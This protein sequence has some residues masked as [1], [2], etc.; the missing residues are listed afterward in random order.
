M[1]CTVPFA[2]TGAGGAHVMSLMA[3]ANWLLPT[4]VPAG[5]APVPV[6]WSFVGMTAAGGPEQFALA[7]K[8]QLPGAQLAL[9]GLHEHFVHARVSSMVP[10]VCRVPYGPE[11]Q[12]AA[13]V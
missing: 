4:G 8:V 3:D 11:G 9:G 2:V 1:S 5:G 13:P 12:A 10:T 7:K 6:H